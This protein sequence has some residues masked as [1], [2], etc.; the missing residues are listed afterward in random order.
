[1]ADGTKIEWSE[2][3]WNPITGCSVV[4]PG[5]AN[6]YAMELAGTR[7]RDHPS[8]AGLTK[9]ANGRPTWTGAVRFNQ[10]WLDQPLRWR[11]PRMI[12]VCAHGDLFHEN[13]PDEW[14]DKVFAVMA[15][16]PQHTFQVLTKRAERMRRYMADR[17]TPD[18]I[19][20]KA[21]EYPEN[22]RRYRDGLA[23]HGAVETD[24]APWPLRHVWLGVSAEDQ[25]RAEE[26]IWELAH[27]PAAL[28]WVSAEP[29]LGLID[30][31]TSGILDQAEDGKR[32]V[33]WV[34]IGGESGKRARWLDLGWARF[35]VEQCRSAGVPVFVKQLGAQPT[36]YRGQPPFGSH[37]DLGLR[38]PKGG[39]P[40]EWPEDLRVREWPRA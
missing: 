5:C 36:V 11:R 17:A 23:L 20:F 3:T 28:R 21:G 39:D 32:A 25:R 13:V 8:R 14:I 7:L 35:L 12:F 10:D 33:D 37:V 26:R 1:M 9:L 31:V 22:D 19:W 38:D 15:L 40:S 2:A 30:A 27:T 16:A 4:S 18:R 24:Q 6:C 34:V 29:L